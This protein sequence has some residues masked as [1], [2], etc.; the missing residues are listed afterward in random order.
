MFALVIAPTQN[1]Q[2]FALRPI[3]F[4]RLSALALA[5]RLAS[6]APAGLI[7]SSVPTNRASL[8]PPEA[9][10]CKRSLMPT[11]QGFGQHEPLIRL[12]LHINSWSEL[13]QSD[14]PDRYVT[15]A[16]EFAA[17]LPFPSAMRAG[18]GAKQCIG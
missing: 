11:L 16:S 15:D 12:D 1:P 5:A 8:S 6:S 10:Y 7:C 17:L 9:Q 13:F 4:L 2:G 3:V 18:D 14:Q